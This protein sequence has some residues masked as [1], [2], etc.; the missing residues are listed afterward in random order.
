[1][2]FIPALVG[3]LLIF[4]YYFLKQ[5]ELTDKTLKIRIILLSVLTILNLIFSFSILIV[6]IVEGSKF[7]DNNYFLINGLTFVF[8][9]VL[10]IITSRLL[11]K[12]IKL[13]KERKTKKDNN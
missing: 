8:F 3:S 13:Y 11:Y 9:V 4:L 12:D 10:T 1:M 2:G 7:N 5:K 6:S